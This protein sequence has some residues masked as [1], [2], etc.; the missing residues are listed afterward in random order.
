MKTPDGKCDDMRCPC[1]TELG[2]CALSACMNPNSSS[3]TIKVDSGAGNT[4]IYVNPN[5]LPTE[6]TT[7]TY[8]PKSDCVTIDTL[9]M[10][11]NSGMKEY[12]RV[13]LKHHT[14]SD[15]L[16]ILADIV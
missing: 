2:Y 5:T 3:A 16:K 4:T 7:T 1:R 6:Y 15:L 11:T 8:P 9:T 13:Y 12:I 10:I 14:L